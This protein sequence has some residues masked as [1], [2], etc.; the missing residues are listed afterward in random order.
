MKFK[1]NDVVWDAE[2]KKAL[3]VFK[4]NTFETKNKYIIDKLIKYGYKTIDEFDRFET[5]SNKELRQLAKDEGIKSW[6]NKKIENI[7]K[8]LRGN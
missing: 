2:R 3:C 4:N 7:L 6:H 1:G 5:L 8:E